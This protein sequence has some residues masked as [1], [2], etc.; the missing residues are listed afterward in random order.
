MRQKAHV[1]TAI[2]NLRHAAVAAGKGVQVNTSGQG[3]PA[4][5]VLD[6]DKWLWTIQ[7]PAVQRAI[8][9]ATLP[10]CC[11]DRPRAN[12]STT[13]CG[14]GFKLEPLMEIT[15][16]VCHRRGFA[17]VDAKTTGTAGKGSIKR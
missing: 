7:K 5:M 14:S 17:H 4:K 15:A 10:M 11:N 13:R 16:N 6:T 2:L 12:L 3:R 9:D 8:Q 1:C